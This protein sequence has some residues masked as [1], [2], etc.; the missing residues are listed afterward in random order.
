MNNFDFFQLCEEKG[1][2]EVV[3]SES[4]R[5]HRPPLA[6]ADAEYEALCQARKAQVEIQNLLSCS[7]SRIVIYTLI[8]IKVSMVY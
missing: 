2:E 5:S 3:D 8:S 1:D 6:E 7:H 4:K